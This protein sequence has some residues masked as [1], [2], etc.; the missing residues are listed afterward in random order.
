ME[1]SGRNSLC[2]RSKIG[3]GCP[4]LIKTGSAVRPRMVYKTRTSIIVPENVRDALCGPNHKQW[5][6]AMK[7]EYA[8]FIKND[9]WELTE[10]PK[11]QKPVGCKSVF[12]VKEDKDGNIKT[13]EA[14][15]VAKGC[16]HKIWHIL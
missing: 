8:S 11:R 13:F 10:L 4:K 9:T 2:Q 12:T 7:S 16:S 14:R 1:P 15:Q 3:P 5:D 6:T